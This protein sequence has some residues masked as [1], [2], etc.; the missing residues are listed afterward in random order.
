MNRE[1]F[2]QATSADTDV[3]GYQERWAEM[4]QNLSKITGLFR[5]NATNSLDPWHLSQDFA[6]LPALNQTFIQD[7][8]PIERVIAVTAEPH[9]LVDMYFQHKATRPLPAD[10]APGLIDHF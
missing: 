6:G 4:R 1:I 5:S 9:F 8:P 10:G 7:D 2:A 3:F